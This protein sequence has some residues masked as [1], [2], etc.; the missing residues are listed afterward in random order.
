MLDD[1][2]DADKS[3]DDGAETPTAADSETVL[4]VDDDGDDIARHVKVDHL[5]RSSDLCEFAVLDKTTYA[6]A[7]VAASRRCLVANQKSITYAAAVIVT[8]R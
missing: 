7:V 3:E 2:D 4:R 8:S 5:R 1:D 6:A